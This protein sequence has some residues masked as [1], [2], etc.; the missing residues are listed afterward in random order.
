MTFCFEDWCAARAMPVPQDGTWQAG[1]PR[2]LLVMLVQQG[3]CALLAEDEQAGETVM[4]APG[5]IVFAAAPVSAV[6]VKPGFALAVLLGGGAP[7]AFAEGLG[8]AGVIRTDEC[9]GVE[10][11]LLRLY[12][13]ADRSEA[14]ETSALA[15]S[16]L[17]RLAAAPKPGAQPPLVTAAM[18]HMRQH[19]GEVYGI[20][21][22]A[23]GLGVSKSHL[24]R[25]FTAS[26]GIPPGRYLTAVRVEAAKRMLLQGTFSLEVIANLCGFSGSNYLCKV[27]KAHTGEPPAAWRRRALAAA[28]PVPPPDEW[29]Q[30]LYL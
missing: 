17:C 21:E 12:E 5:D 4:V 19:Y 16:L 10:A 25:S 8:Q 30:Q 11:L 26:V 9:P 3:E 18:V 6:W 28:L 14:G 22:L 13:G 1:G 15:Y 7:A 20:E 24:I 23:Q 29:E 2:G 27:F